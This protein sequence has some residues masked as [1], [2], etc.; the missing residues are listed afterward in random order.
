M[1]TND[2][3]A[4]DEQLARLSKKS[5]VKATVVLDRAT[6][7]VLK[8]SGQIT[9]I[10]S[11]RARESSALPG[12]TRASFAEESGAEQ[13]SESQG[14]DEFAA[15]VWG[16]VK[17]SGSLVGELDNEVGGSLSRARVLLVMA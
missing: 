5:G 10:R 14:V 17:A 8:T 7:A 3:D 15:M 1:Q 16:F 9:T 6:G 13:S 12:E 4:L 2:Q 11:A